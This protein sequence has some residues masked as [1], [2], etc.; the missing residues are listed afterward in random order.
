MKNPQI[1]DQSK[2]SWWI[3]SRDLL[4]TL[5]AWCVLLYL[6]LP[7]FQMLW[8]GLQV[9][10]GI[11]DKLPTSRARLFFEDLKLFLQ[12]VGLLTLWLISASALRYK[13]LNTARCLTEQPKPLPKDLQTQH[14]QIS[15]MQL[16]ALQTQ[17]CSVVE[18][19]SN[20]KVLSV[21]KK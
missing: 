19:D 15:F 4:L 3:R 2:V 11:Q 18:T 13:R 20:G 8:I 14:H 5:V 21:R 12:L 9:E 10:L 17:K 16:N 7:L 1:I 6:L